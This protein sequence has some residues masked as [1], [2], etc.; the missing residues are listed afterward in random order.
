[1]HRSHHPLPSVLSIFLWV[2]GGNDVELFGLKLRCVVGH[3]L[4]ES[5]GREWGELEE[6]ILGVGNIVGVSEFFPSEK[7]VDSI[8]HVCDGISERLASEVEIL[9]VQIDIEG[10]WEEHALGSGLFVESLPKMVEQLIEH[11]LPGDVCRP[12]VFVAGEK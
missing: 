2:D 5:V 8:H 3:S 7:T 4:D 6:P 9:F 1:M 11:F 10:C 12:V